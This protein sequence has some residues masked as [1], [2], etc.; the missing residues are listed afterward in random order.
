[1]ARNSVTQGGAN[2]GVKIGP[3]VVTEMMF[4]PMAVGAFDNTRDEFIEI[5][6]SSAQTVPLYDPV[7]WT[8]T[9]RI[10]G[11]ADFDFPVNVSLA[12]GEL[13]LVVNFDPVLEP[14]AETAF[15]TK[16]AVPAGVRIYGPLSGKLSNTGERVSLQRPDAPQP[17]EPDT[18]PYIVVDEFTYRTD[19]ASYPFA[20]A[21]GTG[22]SVHRA[23]NSFAEEPLSWTAATPNPGVYDGGSSDADGDGLPADWENAHGLSD[24]SA[25]GANG[26]D[27]DPD[28]DGL[29]N[30]QEYQIGTHPNDASSVLKFT[31]VAKAGN[32]TLTLNA[33]EGISYSVLYRTN[34][35]SGA[36]LKLG[37]V[38][39]GSAR[40]VTI[41]DG[42]PAD[43]TRFY[44]L[45]SPAQP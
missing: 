12:P 4:Q 36:W 43:A 35:A 13:L 2:S 8:N 42:A 29:T 20:G 31:S 5:R 44:R 26:A 33:A 23:N 14:W 18:V 16:F 27:G 24:N 25:T 34:V 11:G 19:P 41:P 40:V 22:Q 45:V 37:D 15:R 28:E 38:A 39:E 21:A 32:T 9:W 1:V 30:M 3:L 6:N 7:H 17:L 10:R